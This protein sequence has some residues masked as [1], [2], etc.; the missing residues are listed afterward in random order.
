MQILENYATTNDDIMEIS[1]SLFDANYYDINGYYEQGELS[2]ADVHRI[3][4]RIRAMRALIK[5]HGDLK[6]H[7][8]IFG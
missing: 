5:A 2:K 6:K 4:S 3:N 1:P 7:P 8:V